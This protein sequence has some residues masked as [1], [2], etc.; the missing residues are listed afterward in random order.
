MSTSAH[1]PS[2]QTDVAWQTRALAPWHARRAWVL[3]QQIAIAETP[4]PTGH[5]SARAALL[6]Q[7]FVAAGCTNVRR[8]HVGN[9]IVR[10]QPGTLHNA[11]ASGGRAREVAA[12]ACLAHLD[13]VFAAD[14]SLRVTREGTQVR[15]PGIGDNSRG[16]AA[17]LALASTLH[18]PEI[19]ARMTRTVDIVATVGEE[20]DGNLRG[21]RAYFDALAEKSELTHAAIAVDGPGD[22]TIVHHAVGSHRMRL[23]FHGQGG[24]SWANAG[25]PNPVHAAGTLIAS[26]ARLANRERPHA[27]ITVSRM[28]GGETLTSIPRD[29]WLDVDIRAIDPARVTRLVGSI[30]QLAERAADDESRTRPTL[31]LHARSEF[32]GERPGGSL[33]I[34]HPLVR[35]AAL[36]TERAGRVPRS[37]SAST[38]ANVP[39]AR[40]IPA[41]AI[42]AGGTGGDAHTP[43]EWFD[44]DGSDVGLVRLLD[45]ITTLA[46]APA[47]GRA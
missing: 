1:G 12:I 25:T 41:I 29:A 15:C 20:G 32:I 2:S 8:D 47:R 45:L 19:A 46:C 27:V 13:T 26:I 38:D 7:R 43:G 31:A 5:E 39:L 23:H 10:I 21:A 36:A 17:M 11:D 14:A 40:D 24:H 4:A 35:A 30:R 3:D 44:D 34:A 33:D 28:G 18:M 16:L 6:Q 42:G 37:A 9:L 22:S